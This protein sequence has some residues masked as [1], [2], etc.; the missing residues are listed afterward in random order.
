VWTNTLPSAARNGGPRNQ[1]VAFVA[2]ALIVIEYLNFAFHN[3]CFNV[4]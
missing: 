4:S 2:N 1:V 3:Q